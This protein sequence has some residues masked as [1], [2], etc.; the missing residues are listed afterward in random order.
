MEKREELVRSLTAAALAEDAAAGDVTTLALVDE[1]RRGT[2]SILARTEGTI[3]GQDCAEA[4]FMHLDPSV[5]YA[6]AAGDGDLVG[7]GDTV[8][9][10]EGS[11]RAILTGE[12]TAL[13]FLGHL[14]GIATLTNA[15]VERIRDTGVV[16]LDTRKTLPGLR[17][18]EKEAVVHGGGRNH[19]R[20]LAGMMLIK[21]NHITAAGGLD[22]VLAGLNPEELKAA[23]I[24][25]TSLEELHVLRA[26]PPGRIML[27]NFSPGRLGEALAELEGWGGQRP[28]IEV[29]GG[30]GLDNIRDFAR[31]GV[32]Y[33]S[34][35]SMTSSAPAFDLSLIVE[36]RVNG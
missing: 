4:V 15:F 16:I 25:V 9:R 18:L 29:S 30:I 26:K 22:H 14:S 24:E 34:I 35:G 8:A 19:R 11:M 33:I 12:R 32:D 10:I 2:A 5:S 28:E 3:S 20:D 7:P 21:E 6:A 1:Q 31:A 27:D 23:E 13:N 36:G 17:D